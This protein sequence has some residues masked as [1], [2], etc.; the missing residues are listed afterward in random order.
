MPVR[1]TIL[2]KKLPTISTEEFHQYW[3]TSHPTTFLSVPIVQRNLS[4]YQQFHTDP[5]VSA[6]LRAQGLPVSEF[7]GGAEFW[8]N[9]YEEAM[10]VFQDPE[11]ERVVVPDEMRFLD[12]QAAR[13]MVGYEEVK[14]EDGKAAEGVKMGHA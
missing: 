4:K 7:D 8:A 11:Y 10:A 3:S 9:S 2:I 12:R 5:A 1:I 13:M 6:A 14:W